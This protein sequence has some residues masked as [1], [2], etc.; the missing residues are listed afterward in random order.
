MLVEL[1]RIDLHSIVRKP[2]HGILTVSVEIYDNTSCIWHDATEKV[3]VSVWLY[4]WHFPTKSILSFASKLNNENPSWTGKYLNFP[5]LVRW[6]SFLTSR[7]WPLAGDAGGQGAG[8]LVTRDCDATPESS[9]G[10]FNV[11]PTSVLSVLSSRRWT[12][13]SP[14]Y[15]AVW[16]ILSTIPDS[17]IHGAN[18]G[19][20]WGRQDPGG[21]HVGPMNLA[22]SDVFGG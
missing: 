12:N 13:F 5:M 4:N 2:F 9:V 3:L 17:K 16:Y 22:I 1:G 11:A 18:M 19:P 6:R 7:A 10:W 15:I 20:I 21:P 8:L 14:T